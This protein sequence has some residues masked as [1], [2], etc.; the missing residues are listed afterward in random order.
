MSKTMTELTALLAVALAERQAAKP[1]NAEDNPLAH[2]T[3]RELAFGRGIRKTADH[4]PAVNM[5]TKLN[6]TSVLA[7]EIEQARRDGL[8]AGRNDTGMRRHAAARARAAR[9][10]QYDKLAASPT[11][12][13]KQRLDA[14]WSVVFPLT[15]IVDKIAESKR[16]WAERFLGSAADDI[17]QNAIEQMVLVMA[18]D[19]RDLTM[20]RRAAEELGGAVER[21]GRLPTDQVVDDA[22][23]TERR[24]LAKARKWLMGMANN[25]VMGAL[26]DAY[27]DQKN[28]RWENIDLIATVMASISGVGNDP[29][30]AN[31]M[32]NKAPLMLGSRF[33]RPGGFD[34]NWLVA[35]ISAGITERKLDRLAELMLDDER[36]RTDGAFLWSENA[37]AV[38]LAGPDGAWK[39]SLVCQATAHVADPRS[40]RARAARMHARNLF[41]WLPGFIV[42]VIESFDL[43][44][45]EHV[46]YVDGQV[47]ALMSSPF[48]Q[49]RRPAKREGLRP[50]LTFATAEDAAAA[51][52][53]YLS[54][55]I[56]EE[57][58]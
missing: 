41:E 38:F 54:V 2:L 17:A 43:R 31:F 9:K 27:T 24:Q 30:T 46:E 5:A 49:L 35:A 44:A 11:V 53:R 21:S 45:T 40:A 23:K 13:S 7:V 20:L 56:A 16:L 14:A 50:A 4:H 48:E 52:T 29:M 33:Q 36:R 6:G 32:A 57:H 58:A 26:V 8:D 34:P 10:A 18:K 1:Y 55:W 19:D 15:E 39:W 42:E 51:L 12:P 37:E 28:L 25:R 47:R 22:A 3:V